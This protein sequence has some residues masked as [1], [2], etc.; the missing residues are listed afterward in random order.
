[1][2][3]HATTTAEPSRRIGRS[4]L[5]LLAGFLF[6]VALSLAT[7]ILVEAAHILPA[8]GQPLN[9]AQSAIA[10]IYRTAYGILSS[11]LVARLAPYKPMGHALTGAAIGMVLAT[12]G[13]IVTWNQNLGP[14]WYPVALVVLALPLGWVGGKLWLM[15]LARNTT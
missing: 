15:H 10:T 1:M 13:V 4:I 8:L 12:V 3:T 7:D 14:H 2:N 11:L 6:N 9:N 5:A